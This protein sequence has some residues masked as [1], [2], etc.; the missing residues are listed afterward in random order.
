MKENLSVNIDAE[1]LFEESGLNIV[2]TMTGV[3]KLHQ[4]GALDL[5]RLVLEHCKEKEITKGYVFDV[6]E[7]AMN[8]VKTQLNQDDE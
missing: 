6:F 5:T 1:D 2:E 7:E 3:M 4:Q 8:V